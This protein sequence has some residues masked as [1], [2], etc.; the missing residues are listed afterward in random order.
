[1]SWVVGGGEGGNGLALE[2]RQGAGP[3]CSAFE[4][5]R[6]VVQSVQGGGGER[7]GRLRCAV[8]TL[9]GGGRAWASVGVYRLARGGARV[10]SRD[11]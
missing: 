8:G 7:N 10:R 4:G 9:R 11:C 6:W 5:G 2:K 3:V 1:M